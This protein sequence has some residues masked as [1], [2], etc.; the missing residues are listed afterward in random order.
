MASQKGGKT[1]KQLVDNCRKSGYFEINVSKENVLNDIKS[2]SL[3]TRLQ[4]SI[5]KEWKNSIVGE[6]K[7]I[8]LNDI[9]ADKSLFHL[10]GPQL[11]DRF[12]TI[13]KQ[14]GRT[15]PFGVAEEFSSNLLPN[16]TS[17]NVIN[18]LP[19]TCTYLSYSHFTSGK[20]AKEEFYKLQRQRKIWWMKVK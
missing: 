16:T 14:L 5:K 20:K 17:E 8:C 12:I 9:V 18:I 13:T 3:G 4:E 7:A 15:I 11:Q 19:D 1:L 2:L 10:N 6:S